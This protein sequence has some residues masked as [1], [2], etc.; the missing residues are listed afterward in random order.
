VKSENILVFKHPQHKYE[1]KL[2]D[3][4]CSIVTGDLISSTTDVS[5]RLQGFTF[6]YQA[7]ESEK[8]MPI[9]QLHLTDTYSFGMLMWRVMVDNQEPMTTFFDFP[10]EKSERQKKISQLQGSSVYLAGIAVATIEQNIGSFEPAGQTEKDLLI[11]I[12]YQTFSTYPLHRNLQKVIDTLQK[13][14]DY[15]K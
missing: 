5:A 2:S 10:T 6:G 8:S 3:F 13:S 4:G 12:F 7:P 14:L 9:G 1:A 11:S 15:G